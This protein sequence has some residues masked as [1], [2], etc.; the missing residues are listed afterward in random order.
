MTDSA[1]VPSR[2]QWPYLGVAAR[3]GATLYVHGI[4]STKGIPRSTLDQHSIDT[5]VDTISTLRNIVVDSRLRDN[6][7]SIDSY[8]S[9][10]YW[11][12]VDQVSIECQPNINLV[13]NWVL[14]K[15]L[16]EGVNQEYW[17]R[18]LI[19]TWLRMPL[20]QII[21]SMFHIKLVQ[22]GHSPSGQHQELRPLGEIY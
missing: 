10:N 8:E 22:R 4:I 18:V 6:L 7:F 17:S 3:C 9:V 19:N 11:L 5:L 14:I 16:I 13:V 15:L 2:I 12:T 20:V 1:F 21:S